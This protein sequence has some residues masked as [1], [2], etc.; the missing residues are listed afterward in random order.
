MCLDPGYFKQLEP[1]LDDTEVEGRQKIETPDKKPPETK[2]NGEGVAEAVVC[3]RLIGLKIHQRK[4][5]QAD[6][7]TGGKQDRQ[8]CKQGQRLGALT[9]KVTPSKHQPHRGAHG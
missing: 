8:K 2:L 1:R 9:P 5:D 3:S 7:E 4:H 6:I